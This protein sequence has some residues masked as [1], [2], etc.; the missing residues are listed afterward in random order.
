MK[1]KSAVCYSF[2]LGAQES[3]AYLR[4]IAPF[5]Q[6]GIGIINGIEDGQPVSELVHNGDIVVIKRWLRLQ[7]RKEN[8]SF[9]N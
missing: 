4:L 1:I 2:S 8:R 7:N 9:L 6:A 5:R 3:M